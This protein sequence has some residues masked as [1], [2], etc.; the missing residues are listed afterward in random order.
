M[1]DRIDDATFEVDL[2]G[3][4]VPQGYLRLEGDF[5]RTVE[6]YLAD[7]DAAGITLRLDRDSAEKLVKDILP[8][9]ERL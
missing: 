3:D 9:L 8:Y 5:T 2:D 7:N 1:T 4:N 6:A